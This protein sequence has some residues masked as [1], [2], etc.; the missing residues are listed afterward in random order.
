MSK[1]RP[2]ASMRRCASEFSAVRH[3]ILR[4][5]S[6]VRGEG[7][8]G[9]GRF[10]SWL[11]AD[12]VLA[13][14]WHASEFQVLPLRNKVLDATYMVCF[15]RRTTFS[16]CVQ[17]GTSRSSLFLCRILAIQFT[18]MRCIENSGWTEEYRTRGNTRRAVPSETPRQWVFPSCGRSVGRLG[19]S[20]CV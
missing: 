12:C 11:H 2:T 7:T 9:L 1:A 3:K 6:W 17:N 10:S 15:Q 8:A 19:G 4:P 16:A 18:G 20:T 13:A 14:R 5:L